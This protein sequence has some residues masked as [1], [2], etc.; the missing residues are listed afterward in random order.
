MKLEFY[1]DKE[2]GG[3]VASII[4]QLLVKI[5][6]SYKQFEHTTI[7]TNRILYRM[8]GNVRNTKFS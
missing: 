7:L 4:T 1:A 6:W 3:G 2:W 5:T 8:R